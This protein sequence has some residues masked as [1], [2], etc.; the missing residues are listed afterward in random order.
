[1]F[2]NVFSKK[3]VLDFRIWK[4][5]AHHFVII[6]HISPDGDAVGSSLAL[7]HYLK[8]LGK[9]T[10]LIVPDN[11][12]KYLTWMPGSDNIMVF[13]ENTDRAAELLEQADVI[14]C[15]D[16]NSSGRVG[17]ASTSLLFSKAKKI[18]IDHHPYPDSFCNL[19]L[20][21]PEISSTSELIFHF[22]CTLGEF[23]N[24]TKEMAECIYVGMMTDT[25]GFVYNSN[26]AQTYF[27][28]GQLIEKGIDK[29]EI[30]RKVYNNYSDSRFKMMGY[31]LYKKMNIFSES[32]TSLI[33]LTVSE[34][35]KFNYTKG[36]T[37]G[38]VNIPLQI[39]GIIFS[40]F[41]VEDFRKNLIK[42]SIRS[43]GD[44]P[45]NRFAADYFNG[46]GHLNASGGEFEGTM[47]QAVDRFKQGMKE[48]SMS[49]D[50]RI[51]QLF[52]NN[53]TKI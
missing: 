28:I 20:S 23:S 35:H 53:N 43:I 7:Y 26:Q 25:G 11:I 36:D 2:D 29:D 15:L 45:C 51:T 22:L 24:I 48:W 10:T 17:Q 31:V 46:G 6:T 27:I 1:M 4:E 40:V 14:C 38:F 47:Q 19:V 30:Y 50:K 9:E 18:M 16:F 49:T 42:I 41:M 3:D 13:E 39:S 8:G 12:P 34:L 21:R 33:T 5:W 52:K 44:V 32:S 37:E